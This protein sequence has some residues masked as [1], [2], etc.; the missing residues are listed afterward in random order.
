MIKIELK[1]NFNLDST[2]TCGQIFR[3]YK[4]ED[5]S[6]D[7][8]LKDRVINVY[9]K[10]NYII[11]SSNNEDDLEI[12]VRNYFDLDNDYENI[13]KYLLEKDSL[14]KDAIMFSCGLMMIRQDPFETLIEYIISANNGVPNIT[15]SLNNIAK[16][17]GKKVLF[18]KKEY[19]LFPSYKDLKDVTKEDFRECK[20]GFRDKYLESIIYKLNNNI[21][22]LDDFNKLDSNE[23]M[24]KLMKNNG[25]GPKVASCILLF[26]YQRYDV[27]PV[28]TWVKKIM[29][30]NYNIIGEKNIREFA[31]KT[32]GKYSA[33]A[34]Q[35]L[36]N[37]SRNKNN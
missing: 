1:N 33:L 35:Y 15:S 9:K 30:S 26:A 2:V 8:I 31:S 25:I 23:A 34:I 22:N 4:L 3:Y 18:N 21:I 20:V 11:A 5:N 27:F 16:R 13:N 19:Y 10:D 37:Y 14:L 12:V 6:Y 24:D 17:Y 32:Y 7:I 28:D 29:E 36:F